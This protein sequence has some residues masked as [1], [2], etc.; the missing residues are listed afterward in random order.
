MNAFDKF[1]LVSG[2]KPNEAKCERAGIGVLKGVSLALCGMNCI[3][4]TK[5]TIKILG[6]HFSDNKILETEE[7]FIRHVRKIGKVLKLWRMRNLTVKG[8][9]TIFKTLAISKIIH[10]SLVTNVPTEIINELNKIQKEFIWNGNNPKIKHS[11]LCNKYKN[12]GLKIVSILSK[13]ISLQC[14]WIKQLC[15]NTSHPWKIIP[16]I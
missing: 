7:N 4:I 3:D 2:L 10:L 5:K 16:L 12:G 13:V 8:K 14:S 11:T 15:D 9:I 1:S 6:I